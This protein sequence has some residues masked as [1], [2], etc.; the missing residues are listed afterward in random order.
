[1][2][3][4][5]RVEPRVSQQLALMVPRPAIRPLTQADADSASQVAREAFSRYV[6]PD[7]EVNACEHFNAHSTPEV[8]RESLQ[9]PAYAAGAFAGASL[10]AFILMPQP[11]LVGMLFVRPAAIRQG[12]GRQLWECARAHIE[13]S[14]PKVVTVELNSSPHA[15]SFYRRLG[16][17]PISAEYRRA[18]SRATRMACWLPARS[19]GAAL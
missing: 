11:S 14:F 4:I 10:V 8:M 3:A 2:I 1:M 17:V 15:T 6:A 13:Q 9:C 16:F 12:V 5:Q 19:L 18:G 7:W